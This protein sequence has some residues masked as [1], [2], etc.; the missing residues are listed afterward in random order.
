MISRENLLEQQLREKIL[1]NKRLNN[2]IKGLDNTIENLNEVV[3]HKDNIIKEARE[4]I[5]TKTLCFA[6]LENYQ[7]GKDI[8]EILDKEVNNVS[9]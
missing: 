3:E 8:L 2:I 4:Y 9:K 6:P 1:E 5:K 7:V